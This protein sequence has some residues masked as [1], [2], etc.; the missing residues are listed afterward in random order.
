MLK[1]NRP[2]PNFQN[3]FG[4]IF[5]KAPP[6]LWTRRLERAP[7]ERRDHDSVQRG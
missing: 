2:F 4:K 7:L 5:K 1:Y 6:G 3:I